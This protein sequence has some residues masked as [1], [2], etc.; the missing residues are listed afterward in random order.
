MKIKTF[1]A[2]N[3]R[4]ALSVVKK[5]LGPEA[6]IL[7]SEDRKRDG[8]EVI[9]AIDFEPDTHSARQYSGAAP[10]A[11]SG[12]LSVLKQEIISLRGYLESMKNSGFELKIPDDKKKIYTFLREQSV[13]E[14]FAVR[15]I[16]R[17]RDIDELEHQ[18][19]DDMN[20][21]KPGRRGGFISQQPALT[22]KRLVMLIGPTGAGKT[23][24]IAKLAANSI[25][26]GKKAALITL[27]TYK[28]GA[29][30]Q[31]RIY[32]RMI[33]IPLDI[34]TGREHMK[35][36]IAR[37][38]DRDVIFIDTSG[39]NPRNE[40]YISSLKSI[41]ETGLPIETQL[42]LSTSSDCDFLMSTRPHYEALPVD[43]IAF[44]KVD[45]AVRLGSMY[46]LSQVFQRPVAYITTGQGVP[47]NIEFLDSRKLT[48]LI[49]NAG[50]A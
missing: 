25:H 19:T 36:S 43:Y 13:C 14:E 45:E 48:G 47:G 3:F 17:V 40:E 46:N 38:S 23:T 49:L 32:S 16:E 1:H 39:Q 10:H 18:M 8:V 21:L 5:D 30:E 22:G 44:T 34:V 11:S 12:E 4:E 37:F 26:E 50:R 41:Y 29:A 28:I 2:R 24:T 33:G 42:L 27:D 20:I 35:K 6:V 9:A 31:I 15:L 7:S